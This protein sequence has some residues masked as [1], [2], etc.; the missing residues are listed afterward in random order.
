MNNEMN[1]AGHL[2]PKEPGAELWSYLRRTAIFFRNLIG[3]KPTPSLRTDLEVAL[4]EPNEAQA[5]FSPQER[6]MLSNILSLRERRVADI[7]VPRADI[8]AVDQHASIG[9][10]LNIFREAGHSRLPVYHETLD[11]LVGMVHIRDFLGYLT[12]NAPRKAGGEPEL[13]NID[14]SMQLSA[15]NIIRPVLFV[16]PSMPAMDLLV[17]MQ[18]TRIHIALVI[19]EYGGT[20]GLVSI[21]DIV[22]E[23]VGDI[24]DEH[25][26]EEAAIAVAEGGWIASARASLDEVKEVVGEDFSTETFGEEMREQAEE[27]DTVGGFVTAIVGRVPARGELI[28][29]SNGYEFEILDAD[30]RRI[31]KLRIRKTGSK[32]AEPRVTRNPQRERESSNVFI[33]PGV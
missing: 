2:P 30:P 28:K 9:E 17:K 22:E 12:A 18:T 16:P 29:C 33:P 19:D 27:I 1:D 8:V 4:S 7:M 24:E 21:E 10:L 6:S 25:D 23:V 15:A 31:K 32:P 20:D 26:E 13:G 3:L 11:D 5:G 14:L